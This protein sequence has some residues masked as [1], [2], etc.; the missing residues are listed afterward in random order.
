M[1]E[2]RNEKPWPILLLLKRPIPMPN[3]KLLFQITDSSYSIGTGNVWLFD[4]AVSTAAVDDARK[5]LS[6]FDN[7]KPQ[8]FLSTWPAAYFATCQVITYMQIWSWALNY[9][10]LQG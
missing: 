8:G 1:K 4:S 7:L 2:F 10:M 3:P 6:V 5:Q 9:L